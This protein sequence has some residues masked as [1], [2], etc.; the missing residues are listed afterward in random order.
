MNYT[1]KTIKGVNRAYPDIDAILNGFFEAPDD[2]TARSIPHHS[3]EMPSISELGN[4]MR[5]MRATIYPGFF[6][7]SGLEKAS[8]RHRLASNL[9]QIFH[10][11]SE[12]IR[13]GICFSLHEENGESEICEHCEEMA[14]DMASDFMKRL[15]KVR[16]LLDSDVLAAYEGDPAAK[17][18]S[19]TI[20][21]YPS[22]HIMTNHRVAHELYSLGVPVI[23]RIINEMGHSKTGIDIHPGATIGE[24]FFI[25]H[26]TGVV[27]GETTII[28]GRCRLYQGV[29][30]G[31]LSFPKDADGNPIKGLPRHP[32][33]EDGVTVY[34]GATILGRVTIGEGSI[35]GGNVWITSDVPK[36][37]RIVQ[38]H[39]TSPS[40][41]DVL[42]GDIGAFI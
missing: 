10:I 34:A 28:G 1:L 32:I 38:T 30:L 40:A 15:P 35:I 22:L 11:L 18:K 36:G 26:G 4:L 24:E 2:G 29:T 25:D 33:L 8:L 41:S 16:D 3:T 21:C 42:Y 17:S 39:S 6:G 7:T 5:L 23:P 27:I 19:E 9:D 37:S 13:V 20:F 14:L 31:A 12:Q